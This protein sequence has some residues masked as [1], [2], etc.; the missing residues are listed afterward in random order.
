V[1]RR[2]FALGTEVSITALHPSPKAAERAISAAFDEMVLVERLMSIYRPDSQLSILNRDGRLREPHPYVV[3]VLRH[4]QRISHATNGALDVTVQPLWEAFATAAKQ[5]RIPDETEVAAARAK[6]DW[7]A[8]AID[9]DAIRFLRP[10]MKITLNGIAQGFAADRVLAALRAEGIEHALINAGELQPLGHSA[11]GDAWSVGIQH[12][13]RDDAFVALTDLDG[14]ALA[15][16]GDYATRF[17]ADGR[18]HHILDPRTGYSPTE[19]CS[20]SILAPSGMAAD[21]LSTACFVLGL[22]RSLAQ[23]KTM[24]RVDAFFVLKDGETVATDGFP[25]NSEGGAA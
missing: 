18:H 17:S 23:I 19:L 6:V 21:A 16:S 5:Q 22:A 7:R 24:R 8:V 3:E 4:A 14:R 2:T 25:L 12:P 1:T 15:T 20:V 9:D 10:G 13:R 11:R